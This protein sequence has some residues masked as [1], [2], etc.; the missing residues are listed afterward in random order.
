MYVYIGE[1]SV[2]PHRRP[3][4][5]TTLVCADKFKINTFGKSA[6]HASSFDISDC[7][8]AL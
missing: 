4:R 5:H 2:W 6:T 8:P 7:S 1:L 3:P